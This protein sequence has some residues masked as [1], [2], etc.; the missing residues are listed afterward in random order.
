MLVAVV[1]GNRL[2][3]DGSCTDIMMARL[4][5]ALEVDRFMKPDKII[6]SGGV[7]NPLARKSEAQA[8]FDWLVVQGINADKLV[9]E[10]K[11]LT[12]KQ[13]AKFSVPIALQLGAD[14]ILVCTTPEHMHRKFL[15][16]I[17]LFRANLRKTKVALCSCCTIA[18]VALGD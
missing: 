15:N 7:A 10:D 1:L 5:L 17:K 8:M 12:T 16:P 13:N 14:K 3:D 11:S 6:L 18:D 9:L 4:N 2:K